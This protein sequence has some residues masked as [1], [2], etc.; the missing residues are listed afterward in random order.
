MRVPLDHLAG[1][2]LG[3]GAEVE[4]AAFL[5]QPREQEDLEEEVAELAGE[6][7]R[8]ALVDRREGFVGLLEKVGLEG[9]EGL[10]AIPGTVAAQPFDE[11]GQ[12][13]EALG[14]ARIITVG[15]PC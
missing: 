4:P 1:D 13:I 2:P 12:A 8:F 15:L 6:G 3:D 9:V 11:R 5:G 10:L 7:L 14:H